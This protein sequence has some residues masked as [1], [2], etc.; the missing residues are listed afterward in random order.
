[1]AGGE[2]SALGTGGM[3][4]KIKAAKLCVENGADMVIANGENPEVLYDLFDG[5]AKCTVFDL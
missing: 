5:T 2:G 3:R 1:M 4:T